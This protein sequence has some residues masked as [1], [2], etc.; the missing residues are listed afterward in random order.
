MTLNGVMAI[1]L[2]H[3]TEL[4]KPALQT[5][6]A[7]TALLTARLKLCDSESI[8]TLAAVLSAVSTF[9]DCVVAAEVQYISAIYRRFISP[10]FARGISYDTTRSLTCDQKLMRVASLK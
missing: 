4:G 2:R 1:T 10:V 7:N 5:L 8:T 6:V 9:F 3:F